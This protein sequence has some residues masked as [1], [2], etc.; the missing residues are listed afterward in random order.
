M[1]DHLRRQIVRALALQLTGLP[2]TG[3][4][5]FVSRRH[6]LA[7]EHLP[8]LCV[9]A[10]LEVSEIDSMGGS[11]GLARTLDLVVE[12][13]AQ[14]ND[15]LDAG[16]DQIAAEVETALAAGPT[17]GGLCY[18]TTLTATRI[19]LQPDQGKGEAKTGS[20]V[21]TFSAR[22]RTMKSDPTSNAI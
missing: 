5:V 3:A 14:D 8:G 22:Y 2:T 18:E 9:Y 16:L 6:P 20:I 11:R 4:R 7:A 21:M 12:G 17:L 1:A 13:V 19:A 15:G 10:V